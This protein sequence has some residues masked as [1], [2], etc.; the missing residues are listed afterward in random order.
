MAS[1]NLGRIKGDKGDRGDIGPKGDTGLK[2]DKG[3]KG[4]NGRD[5]MTP[6]FRVGE[7]AT[8]SSAE[9]AH[10]ELDCTNAQNPVLSFYIPRGKDGK[11]ATGDMIKAVY[12]TKGIGTD[13]YEYA[14]NLADSCVKISGGTLS[15]ALKAAETVL[16]EKAVR[17]IS[18]LSDFPQSGAEGDLCIIV[19]NEN[20]KRLGEC[21]PGDVMLIKENGKDT[22]YL[23]V[24][25]DF[26]GSNSTTLVRKDLYSIKS[27]YDYSKRGE[28]PMSDIDVF[29]EGIYKFALHNE[30]RSALLP[31]R[32]SAGVE[33]YCFLLSKADFQNISYFATESNRIANI[34]GG[35]IAREYMTQSINGYRKIDSI[36]T[37]GSFSSVEL[38][39]QSLFRPTIVLPADFTVVNTEHNSLPAVK[40]LEPRCGIYV[41]LKGEWKECA[42]L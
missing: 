35:A 19:K 4:D 15:G 29:L 12:D 2:G 34:D 32:L 41:Y 16:S 28:Y 14:K 36:S 6:V 25:A 30:I 26:H 31:A 5:G 8:L 22:P 20:S 38:N 1:F 10:V 3:D 18:V 27:Y 42:L 9:E 7:T 23:I 17:N 11:D 13:I 33:R 39:E 37:S 21:N 24:A 40:P